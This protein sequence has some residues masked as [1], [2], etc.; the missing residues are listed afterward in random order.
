MTKKTFFILLSIFITVGSL[1]VIKY[2]LPNKPLHPSIKVA[3]SSD[4]PPFEFTVNGKIV[5]FDIDILEEISKRTGYH[6][7]IVPIEFA[8]IIAGIK[9]SL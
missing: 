7:E 5:G 9:N 6:F 3:T 2:T 1:G 4:F 8:G